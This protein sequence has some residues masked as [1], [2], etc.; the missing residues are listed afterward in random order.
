NKEKEYEGKDISVVFNLALCYHAKECVNN[1]PAVF[2]KDAR[3]WINPDMSGKDKIIEVVKKCPSGALSYKLADEHIRDFDGAQK[4][5][6]EKDGP[7][8]VSGNIEL[9]IEQD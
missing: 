3:P 1:L 5:R 6:I 4:I 8:R 2:D 9:K 7:Y